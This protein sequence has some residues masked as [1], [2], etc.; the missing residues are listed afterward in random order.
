MDNQSTCAQPACLLQFSACGCKQRSN[1]PAFIA[2][3]TMQLNWF[4]RKKEGIMLVHFCQNWLPIT[5]RIE[6][7]IATLSFCHF[8]NTLQPY[9]SSKISVH[10]PARTLHSGSNKLL[11][12]SKVKLRTAGE[13]TFGLHAAKIWNSLPLAKCL[14]QSLLSFKSNL[15]NLLYQAIPSKSWTEYSHILFPNRHSNLSLYG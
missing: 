14:I 5:Q 2:G 3:R 7:K 8:D 13:K 12:I 6:Y 1:Q 15:K 9:H 10:A 4:V 11:S